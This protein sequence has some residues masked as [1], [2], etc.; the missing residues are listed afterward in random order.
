MEQ[1]AP[2]IARA[3]AEFAALLEGLLARGPLESR[4][5]IRYLSMQYHLTRGVQRYFLEAAAHSGLAKRRALRQFLVSFANEEELHYLVAA[6]DLKQLGVD[7]LPEPLDVTLWHSYFRPITVERPF[8]RLGAACTLENI[9]G[10]PARVVARQAL[11]AS[12]LNRENTRFLVLHQHEA[13][14]HGEQMLSALRDARLDAPQIADLIDGARK[15]M[16][17]Y[18]R[19][20]SW[21][22]NPDNQFCESTDETNTLDAASKLEIQRF[23]MSDLS[24]PA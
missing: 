24:S 18:L 1:I 3:Q 10:G 15:G 5:Y 6:S 20:A 2:I 16:V 13:N 19:M 21:A 11:A 23:R 9:S 14:P 8:I 22:I 12:F 17:M 7:P 4:I